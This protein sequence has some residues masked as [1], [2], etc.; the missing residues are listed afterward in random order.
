MIRARLRWFGHVER[1]YV[2][3]VVKRL[4]EIEGNLI[5]RG[6]ER[7]KKTIKEKS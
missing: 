1:K 4:D 5:A 6:R 3:Y 7:P 2:D